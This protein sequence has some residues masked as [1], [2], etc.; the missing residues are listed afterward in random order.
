M[1]DLGERRKW[2][3]SFAGPLPRAITPL[4][5]LKN[6]MKILG[7]GGEVRSLPIDGQWRI[8]S[9]RHPALIPNQRT[10]SASALTLAEHNQAQGKPRTGCISSQ[11]QSHDS[12]PCPERQVE[13]SVLFL[14]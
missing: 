6:T 5:P 3:S 1:K 4:A 12:L 7:M 8:I 13:L 10:S 11:I 2:F 14:R 9:T